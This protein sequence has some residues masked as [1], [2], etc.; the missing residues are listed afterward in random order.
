MTLRSI[1]VITWDYRYRSVIWCILINQI[2]RI[3]SVTK[4]SHLVGLLVTTLI[5]RV[6]VEEFLGGIF[7]EIGIEISEGKGLWRRL[8]WGFPARVL[9][10]E[11][12]VAA[13]G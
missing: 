11:V 10:A 2:A 8:V 13:S 5:V 7:G 12:V 3:S 9:V 4:H 1:Y 6:A